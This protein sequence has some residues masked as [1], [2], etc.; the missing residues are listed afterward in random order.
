[1]IIK[2]LCTFLASVFEQKKDLFFTIAKAV[3]PAE[4]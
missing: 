1:M 2:M 3:L 4:W